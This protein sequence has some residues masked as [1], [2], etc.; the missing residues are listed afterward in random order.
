ML[1]VPV[2]RLRDR[3]GRGYG[4]GAVAGYRTGAGG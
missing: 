2:A 3:R 4:T 1:E